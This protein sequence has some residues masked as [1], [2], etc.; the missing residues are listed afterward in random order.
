[1]IGAPTV[2]TLESWCTRFERMSSRPEQ[3]KGKV[4]VR[5]GGGAVR[6]TFRHPIERLNLECHGWKVGGQD[7]DRC[8][9]LEAIQ[10]ALTDTRYE[11]VKC[12]NFVAEELFSTAHL[13]FQWGSYLSDSVT[14]D[15]M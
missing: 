5:S 10:S 6:V 12:S 7:P 13:G 1:M 11:L 2:Q 8:L 15:V 3:A 9:G 14:S 4:G